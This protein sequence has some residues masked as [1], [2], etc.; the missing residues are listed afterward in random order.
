MIRQIRR[1]TSIAF[2]LVMIITLPMARSASLQAVIESVNQK[3]DAAYNA[4]D[5]GAITRLYTEQAT[6]F[7]PGQDMV[8][9]RDGTASSGP[10]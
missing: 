1:T 7:P 8:I 10:V 4:H 5:A 6:V 9:G 3:F 2:A